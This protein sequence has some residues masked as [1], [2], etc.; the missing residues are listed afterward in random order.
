MKKKTQKSKRLWS[1]KTACNIAHEQEICIHTLFTKFQIKHYEFNI[2]KSKQSKAMS[3]GK[4]DFLYSSLLEVCELN[5]NA[6]QEKRDYSYRFLETK[7]AIQE[8]NFWN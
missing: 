4:Q 8:I 2:M 6:N 1:D 7:R 3:N 5:C